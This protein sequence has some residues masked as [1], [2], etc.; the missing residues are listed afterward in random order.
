MPII[1]Q[2]NEEVKGKINDLHG[3]ENNLISR[4]LKK[5]IRISEAT[6]PSHILNTLYIP[7]SISDH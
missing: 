2:I 1:M 7:P 3:K 5:P 4:I 6:F